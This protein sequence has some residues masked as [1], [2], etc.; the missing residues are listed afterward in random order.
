MFYVEN[1]QLITYEENESI[2]EI[3]NFQNR[4]M[5]SNRFIDY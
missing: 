3:N 5:A 4:M 1:Y 2:D